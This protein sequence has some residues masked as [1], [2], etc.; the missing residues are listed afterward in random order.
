MAGQAKAD[1]GAN[2]IKCSYSKP[3]RF[4]RRVGGRATAH[5]GWYSRRF[6]AGKLAVVKDPARTNAAPARAFLLTTEARLSRTFF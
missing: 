1:C 2:L 5:E 6:V 3:R 4:A